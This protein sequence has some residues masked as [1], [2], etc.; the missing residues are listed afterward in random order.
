MIISFLKDLD[1]DEDRTTFYRYKGAIYFDIY[2]PYVKQHCP[3]CGNDRV[4][5]N[6][7][8]IRVITHSASTFE[9]IFLNL[10][11]QKFVCSNCKYKFEQKQKICPKNLSIS[12]PTII[13]IL[14]KLTNPS[15]T[16]TSVAS[17]LFLSKQNVIDVFDRYIDYKR[18]PLS[19]HL[20]FDEKHTGGNMVDNYAFVIQ[21]WKE[22]KIIDIYPTRKKAKL[23]KYFRL[24]PLE[25]RLRVKTISIDMWETYLELSK[26]FFP[27]AIIAIDSFHVIENINRVMNKVRVKIMNKFDNGA[28]DLDDNDIYYYMLKKFA[29]YFVSE[30]DN[31]SDTRKIP[32]MKTKW[33]KQEILKYLLDIDPVLKECY[34][35]VCD[36]REFNRSELSNFSENDLDELIERF[37][38]CSSLEFRKIGKMLSIW[39]KEILNSLITINDC[40]TVPNKKDEIPRLRRL[41]NGPIEGINSILEKILSN[42]N[43]YTN[44]KRFRNRAMLCV[45]KTFMFRQ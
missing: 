12:T 13:L 25:E 28:E 20:S 19:E 45:N 26:R 18:L 17:D 24:I 30:F 15:T 2:L 1:I 10:H 9:P 42:G 29:H 3:E 44:F 37:Y 14:E 27:N 23:E 6:G 38:K 31:L 22:N 16:F 39:K 5:K 11:I 36:Y 7:T 35:L 8:Y 43:G 40:Y 4:Y 41:S 32:K 34:Q 21:D 33:A